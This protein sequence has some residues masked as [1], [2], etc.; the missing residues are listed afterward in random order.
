MLV[1]CD[2][3]PNYTQESCNEKGDS[4][5]QNDCEKKGIPQD[6]NLLEVSAKVYWHIE[7]PNI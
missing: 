3:L 7:Y 2:G 6:I 5:L 1:F 4:F